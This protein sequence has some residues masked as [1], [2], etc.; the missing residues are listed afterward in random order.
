MGYSR[1]LSLAFHWRRSII[2]MSTAVS[3]KDAF[4]DVKRKSKPQSVTPPS[5]QKTS[6]QLCEE[7]PN[8]HACWDWGEPDAER[9][10]T[11]QLVD[12]EDWWL[13]QKGRVCTPAK[14]QHSTEEW[15]FCVSMQLGSL[16]CRAPKTIQETLL[17]AMEG[18]LKWQGAHKGSWRSVRPL[19]SSPL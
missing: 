3:D 9:G 15:N 8:Q 18:L 2:R 10:C 5:A 12:D 14:L 6:W 13:T 17:L 11:G 4:T 7:I 19:G 1:K 16:C